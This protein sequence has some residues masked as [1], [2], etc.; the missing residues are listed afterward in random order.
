L[1]L[2]SSGPKPVGAIEKILLI[3][4]SQYF[5]RGLLQ[6]LVLEGGNGDWPLLPVLLGDV[7]SAERLGLILSLFEPLMQL[8]DVSLCVPFVL[9]VGDAVDPCA[10]FL[11]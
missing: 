7:D 2:P 11:S 10:G 4:G 6:D 1:V 5:D 3:D 9:S 8:S